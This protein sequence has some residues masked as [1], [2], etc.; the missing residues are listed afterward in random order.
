L[1]I[2]VRY[3]GLFARYVGEREWDFDVLKGSTAGDLLL[4]IAGHYQESLPESIR[5]KET[6]R[7]HRSVRLARAGGAISE[8]EKL[9][10]GDDLIVL[11]T[12]AGG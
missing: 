11:F 6:G 7:L 10:D 8:D 12:L 5:D 1:K 4:T 9:Q 2:H 3:V